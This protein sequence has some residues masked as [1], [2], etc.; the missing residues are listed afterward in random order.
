MSGLLA[1]YNSADFCS[2]LLAAT[3]LYVIGDTVA[4]YGKE[5][6]SRALHRAGLLLIGLGFA[7]MAALGVFL[8]QIAKGGFV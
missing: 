3:A 4:C 1:I 6:G 2:A 7:G 5:R 8:Y